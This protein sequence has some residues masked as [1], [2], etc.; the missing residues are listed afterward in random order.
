MNDFLSKIFYYW[1]GHVFCKIFISWFIH[2]NSRFK[3]YSIRIR[4]F[5]EKL[6]KSWKD[7]LSCRTLHLMN[8]KIFSHLHYPDETKVMEPDPAAALKFCRMFAIVLCHIWSDTKLHLLTVAHE[9]LVL[10][11]PI[12]CQSENLFRITYVLWHLNN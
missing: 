11:Y 3:N 8:E 2:I 4:K 9:L 1:N 6:G 10:K 5:W 12:T 7:T